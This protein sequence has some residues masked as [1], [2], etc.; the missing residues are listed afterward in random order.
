MYYSDGVNDYRG[1]IVNYNNISL[2][3]DC[4]LQKIQ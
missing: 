4:F 2:E 3:N 1:V